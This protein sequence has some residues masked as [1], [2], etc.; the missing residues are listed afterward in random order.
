MSKL[1]KKSNPSDLDL[2]IARSHVALSKVTPGTA[3]YKTA[4]TELS[5]LYELR[6]ADKRATDKLSKDTLASGIFATANVLAVILFE[7]VGHGVLTSK[8]M[9]MLPKVKTR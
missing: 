9:S 3:E 6:N 4:L 2:E 5:S 1:Q 8:S 7:S